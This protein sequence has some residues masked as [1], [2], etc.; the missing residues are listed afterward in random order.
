MRA[1]LSVLALGLLLVL[2]LQVP[3]EAGVARTYYVSTTGGNIAPYTN[4]AMAARSIQD[5]VD[6]W[7]VNTDTVL[8]T[9]GVY[10]VSSQIVLDKWMTLRSVNGRTKSRIEASGATRCLLLQHTNAVVDGFAI[11]GGDIPG[12][13]GAGAILKHGGEVHGTATAASIW[14]T[15]AMGVA[16]AVGAYDVAVV[17]CLFAVITL[18]ILSRLKP[19]ERG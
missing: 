11:L 17:I 2:L 7:K 15:G 13:I 4:W 3:V 12:F 8:V 19:Q 1:V 18:Y 16:V 9:D 5:A 6:E 14:A 10:T